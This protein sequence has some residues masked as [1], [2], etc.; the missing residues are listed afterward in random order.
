MSYEDRSVQTGLRYA[1]RIQVLSEGDH[2]YSDEV[3][4]SVPS[5][6]A[7][8]L[9]LRLDPVFPN[10]LEREARFNFAVPRAGR[11]SLEIFS[12]SGQ[13]VATIVNQELTAG[14]RLL[15]WDGRDTSGQ[16]VASGTYFARLESAGETRFRKVVV[17]R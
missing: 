8:P 7:A 13:R 12:V 10:P 5:E 15:S 2:G 17:A 3:W 16:A 11:V 9:T 14:W 1:Y 4:V 6:A